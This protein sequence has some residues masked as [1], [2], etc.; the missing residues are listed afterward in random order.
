[1]GEELVKG[2]GAVEG[3][4]RGSPWMMEG[5]SVPGPRVVLMSH[6]HIHF[7]KLNFEM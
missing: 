6:Y 7:V 2:A 5:V 1:M 4:G 3:V